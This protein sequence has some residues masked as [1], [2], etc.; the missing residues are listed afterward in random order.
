MTLINKRY[1]SSLKQ[2]E[3]LKNV[4]LSVPFSCLPIGDFIRTDI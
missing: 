4:N 1:N 3:M 2:S